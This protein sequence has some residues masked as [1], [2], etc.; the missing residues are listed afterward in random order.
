MNAR[1]TTKKVIGIVDLLTNQHESV[2]VTYVV[3]PCQYTDNITNTYLWEEI[4]SGLIL[5]KGDSEGSFAI[6]INTGHIAYDAIEIV[7]DETTQYL[8]G[9]R[10]EHCKRL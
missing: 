2:T 10:S 6:N 9:F 7:R 1:R 8:K 5:I 3:Q 4:E